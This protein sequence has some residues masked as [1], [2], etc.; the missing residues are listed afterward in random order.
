VHGRTQVVAVYVDDRI[1][2]EQEMDR[3]CALWGV[4]A[5]RDQQRISSSGPAQVAATPARP[6]RT[7]ILGGARSGKSS[8]AELRLAGEPSVT[9]LAAGPW[10]DESW[11]DADGGQDIEWVRRVA[12]HR[13]ARPQWWRTAESLDIAGA[14]RRESGALLIDGIGTW[15]AAIM[16]QAGAWAA[17]TAGHAS[18]GLNASPADHPSHSSQIS[19]EPG[20][21]GLRPTGPQR[22][23]QAKIDDLIGAWRQTKSLV[24]AVT[25]QVGSGLVP[26]YPAGRMFRDELGRLNQRLAAESDISLLVVAGRPM[27]LPA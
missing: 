20:T 27:T 8:E 5:G 10:P 6:H 19:D 3:R 17:D 7:L 18:N 4:I 22:T 11:R 25:D 23:V 12:A 14:L 16:D 24:V 13:A 21:A 9:Y 26:A 1:T 2:S 15:L